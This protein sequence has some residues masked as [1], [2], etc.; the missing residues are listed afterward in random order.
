MKFTSYV[1]YSHKNW[2][3]LKVVILYSSPNKVKSVCQMNYPYSNMGTEQESIW[4]PFASSAG[5]HKLPETHRCL[6]WTDI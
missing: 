4:P 3:G 5:L 1:L 2:S 6:G